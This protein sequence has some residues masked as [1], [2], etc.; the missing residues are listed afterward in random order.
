MTVFFY[1]IHFVHYAIEPGESQMLPAQCLLHLL[2]IRVP[3][4]DQLFGT[5][6]SPSTEG[7]QPY[8]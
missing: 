8:Y 4:V 2:Q 6:K 3:N 5:A 1:I 7:C